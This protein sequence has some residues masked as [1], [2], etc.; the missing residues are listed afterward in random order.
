MTNSGSGEVQAARARVPTEDLFDVGCS[1]HAK[2]AQTTE[3]Q[4]GVTLEAMMTPAAMTTCLS[5][6]SLMVN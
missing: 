2:A 5:P 4:R 3:Y 6:S 1:E